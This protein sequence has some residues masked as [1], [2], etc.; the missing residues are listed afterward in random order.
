MDFCKTNHFMVYEIGDIEKLDKKYYCDK[1]RCSKCA[2]NFTIIDDN[3]GLIVTVLNQKGYRVRDSSNN[4]GEVI[5]DSIYISFEEPYVFKKTPTGFK[6]YSKPI[7][8]F[9]K[10]I[11]DKDGI[12]LQYNTWGAVRTLLKWAEKLPDINNSGEFTRKE[13]K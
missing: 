12:K 1:E 2:N 10:T 11:K 13:C 5:H 7:T 8:K 3:L 6:Y 9:Y 4:Y